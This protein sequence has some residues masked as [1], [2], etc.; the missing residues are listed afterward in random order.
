M[1]LAHHDGHILLRESNKPT[2]TITPTPAKLAAFL[3]GVK[4]GEFDHFPTWPTRGTL[5]SERQFGLLVRFTLRDRQAAAAFDEL[6]LDTLKGIRTQEPGTLAY[7]TH[8]PEGEPLV[9]VFYELYADR[10][11]FETH[12]AQPHTKRFLAEREQYLTGVDVSFLDA[13]AGKVADQP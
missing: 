3:R 6:V 11:A 4:A 9:R 8:I 10:A 7:V 13:V 1:E 12:E 5:M 2:D